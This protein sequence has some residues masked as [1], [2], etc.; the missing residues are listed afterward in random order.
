MIG[1]SRNYVTKVQ[2][3]VGKRSRDRAMYIENNRRLDL[4]S[5]NDMLQV[6]PTLWKF[7][8]MT[9]KH[10]IKNW[11]VGNQREK[12]PPL[13]FWDE[14]HVHNITAGK[15]KLRQ[16]KCVMQVVERFSRAEGIYKVR[17]GW[18]MAYKK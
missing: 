10:L 17:E 6:F 18:Y 15:K 2:V 7:P 11:H 8:K 9:V 5:H 4:G 1:D 16:M 12:V 3:V 14:K 13:E